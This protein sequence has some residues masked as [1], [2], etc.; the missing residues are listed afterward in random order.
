MS[1]LT[2]LNTN[3]LFLILICIVI[4]FFGLEKRFYYIKDLEGRNMEDFGGFRKIW[5]DL[6]R[7][8]RH[9]WLSV[10]YQKI[11]SNTA[12]YQICEQ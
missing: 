6:Y 2:A 1:F 3:L 11:H 10:Y 9:E 12:V 7:Y 8:A 5:E 4:L